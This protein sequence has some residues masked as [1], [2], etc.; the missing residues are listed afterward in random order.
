MLYDAILCKYEYEYEYEYEGGRGKLMPDSGEWRRY[1]EE[2]RGRAKDSMHLEVDLQAWRDNL[3]VKNREL[4]VQL[5]DKNKKLQGEMAAQ[6]RVLRSKVDQQTG[7]YRRYAGEV[8]VRAGESVPRDMGAQL[9]A[10]LAQMQ[11]SG[12]A[13]ARTGVRTLQTGTEKLQQ[14]V[15]ELQPYV[16]AA[17]GF[18]L[19]KVLRA[20]VF[21]AGAVV[22]ARNQLEP[23]VQQ[24][25]AKTKVY[26]AR[27]K[28]SAAAKTAQA[29]VVA[30]EKYARL[31]LWPGE[32]MP[33]FKRWREPD[34]T[35]C[36]LKLISLC[37]KCGSRNSCPRL[38]L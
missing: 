27:A 13:A 14:K 25:W 10:Q 8:R 31:K 21:A 7:I 26:S 17:G 4:Q 12:T 22:V 37:K 16:K 6:A 29:Q 11:T 34:M 36:K 23:W 28:A 32:N 1:F 35:C 33:A 9:K 38:R 2:V 15:R 3:Q 30:R 19:D 24:T 5:Q 20:G 18:C